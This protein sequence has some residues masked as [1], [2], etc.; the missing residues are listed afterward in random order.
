MASNR[1][2]VSPASSC[3]FRVKYG[4]L[5]G[6]GVWSGE[7]RMY[8]GHLSAKQQGV[9]PQRRRSSNSSGVVL[10]GHFEFPLT[11]RPLRPQTGCCIMMFTPFFRPL[12]SKH[13]LSLLLNLRDDCLGFFLLFFTVVCFPSAPT[14]A[15]VIFFTWNFAVV[16]VEGAEM[17]TNATTPSDCK[18]KWLEYWK[19]AGLGKGK[20]DREA[21][22]GGGREDEEKAEEGEKK[23]QRRRCS[24]STRGKRRERG[25]GSLRTTHTN[26]PHGANWEG[27][28]PP[29]LVQR[30]RRCVSGPG[31]EAAG[32]S[33]VAGGA[34]PPHPSTL[35]LPLTFIRKKATCRQERG[36]SWL[37]RLG[38][39]G[40]V[41]CAPLFQQITQCGTRNI[42][43]PLHHVTAIARGR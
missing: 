7:L 36:V 32:Y 40:F 37:H 1:A 3:D 33:T 35:F 13:S 26:V 2:T 12:K 11:S 19:E 16:C 29:T 21:K 5:G 24:R 10:H 15:S 9:V 8:S 25:A 20:K 39:P 41:L 4:G 31:K 14:L 34:P 28:C 27:V 22:E 38:S 42:I 30:S 23:E 17:H 6:W 43:P 18:N